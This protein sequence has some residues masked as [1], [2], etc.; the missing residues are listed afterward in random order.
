[1]RLKTRVLIIVLSSLVGL[2]VMGLFGLYSMRQGMLEER[3]AQITLLLDFADS[4][5]KHYYELE[6]AGTLTREEAQTRAK[7]AIGAQRLGDDYFF[8]R[9]LKD[10][11]FVLHPIKERMGKPDDGGRQADG[12]TVVQMYRDALAK[13]QNNKAFI[14]LR[15]QKPSA[16]DASQLFP[17]LNGALKFE[18]WGWMPGIGFFVDDIDARF[19]RQSA[20]FLVVAIV[21]LALLSVLIFK[22]RSVIL[23]Q[24]GGEPSD[25]AECMRRIA[26]GDL[27]VDIAVDKNDNSSLM[28]SLKLMQ[29]KLTNLT[30]SIQEN[31]V[32][33]SDQVQAFD[34][35]AKT[36]SE[37]NSPETQADLLRAVKKLGKTANILDKSIARIKL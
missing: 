19:W 35:I 17:K 8:I 29:M 26:S 11:Y 30:S 24:L 33:L 1:M 28:A 32:T 31:A 20:V 12:R 27:A 36:H 9:S 16:R 23:R 22:M 4:Q 10:D 14:D 21:L 13:S 37:A 6:L 7:E 25:A 5:L 15:T 18:P 34:A 2:M 3:R